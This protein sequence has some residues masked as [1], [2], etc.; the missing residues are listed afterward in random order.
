[1]NEYRF[2]VPACVGIA[3]LLFGPSFGYRLAGLL[4]IAVAL[5]EIGVW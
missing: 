4:C 2:F 3:F 5:K 1:M